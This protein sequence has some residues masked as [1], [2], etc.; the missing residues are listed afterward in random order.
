MRLSTNKMADVEHEECE[1]LEII[2]EVR[3]DDTE[4][5]KLISF[6]RERPMLWDTSMQKLSS[7]EN[8]SQFAMPGSARWSRLFP[9][10]LLMV[11]WLNPASVSWC[12]CD[13]AAHQTCFCPSRNIARRQLLVQII[14]SRF[15]VW[16]FSLNYRLIEVFAQSSGFGEHPTRP[17]LSCTRVSELESGR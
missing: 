12:Q 5:L 10:N 2:Q 11:S 16:L 8:V 6:Y 15:L 13:R 14:L 1:A 4:R 17:P 3:L 7:D 9:L